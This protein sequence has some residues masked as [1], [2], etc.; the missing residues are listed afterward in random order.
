MG[1]ATS[2]Y[3]LTTGRTL[4]RNL[5]LTPAAVEAVRKEDERQDAEAARKRQWLLA[6]VRAVLVGRVFKP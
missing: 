6:E 3:A 5:T 1:R 4:V 2:E